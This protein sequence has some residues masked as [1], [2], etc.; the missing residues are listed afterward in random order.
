M[1][2]LVIYAASAIDLNSI[3]MDWRNELMKKLEVRNISATLFDPST[4]YK[5]SCYGSEP[6]L[7]RS[8]YIERI[9]R[10]ALEEA[11]VF[12]TCMSKN[13]ASVGTPIELD[14]AYNA[15]KKIYV[16]SDIVPGSSVYVDNRVD[17]LDCF[18]VSNMGNADLF[19]DA[20]VE[21]ADR[22]AAIE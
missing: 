20:L 21:L 2:N 12:V 5:V 6:N 19:D 10:L 3:K 13:V 8:R 17:I 11:S 14:F 22:L 16:I 1:K 9:N 7:S 15:A 18:Y 4:A